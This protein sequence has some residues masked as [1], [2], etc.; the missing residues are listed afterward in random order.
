MSVNLAV[1][2]VTDVV[3]A[4]DLNPLYIYESKMSLL[5]R[6]A[7]GRA[8]AERLVESRVVPTLAQCDF[9]DARPEMDQAFVG[10]S[11]SEQPLSLH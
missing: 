1:G 4:E 2:I 8:G 7:Q 9:I 3:D 10:R 6:M 11:Y 5:C